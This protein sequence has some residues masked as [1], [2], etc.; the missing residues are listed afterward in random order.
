MAPAGMI[1]ES[2]RPTKVDRTSDA[3][4]LV[5]TGQLVGLLNQSD[6][7]AVME[8]IQR[9]SDRKLGRTGS[10]SWAAAPI[11]ADD[12][13]K[14]L[15]SCGYVKAADLADRYGNPGVDPEPLVALHRSHETRSK[16]LAA[17]DSGQS[18]LPAEDHNA[19]ETGSGL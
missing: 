19:H 12:V 14:E 9:I 17:A 10:N 1:D 16:F 7:V 5:D 6:A 13:V 3:T 18:R 2:I 8:A 11:N 15:V 4:G